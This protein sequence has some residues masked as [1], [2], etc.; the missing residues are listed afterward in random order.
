VYARRGVEVLLIEG[1]ILILRG[2]GEGGLAKVGEAKE[3]IAEM[4]CHRWNLEV[5]RI[6][7]LG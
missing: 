5:E 3:L 6:R 7:G 1:E 2:D 4:G